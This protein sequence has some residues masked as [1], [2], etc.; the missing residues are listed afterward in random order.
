MARVRLADVAAQ[1]GVSAKTVSNVVHGTGM[2]SAPVRRRV[3]E[4]I[5]E[6]GYR[7]NLAARQLRN[8]TSGL[9]ALAIPDLREPYFAEFAS[10]FFAAAQRRSLTVLVSQTHGR[11]ENELQLY[12]GE[13]LPALEGLVMNPLALSAR[14]IADRRSSVPLVLF[15]EHGETLATERI[16]H[17]GVDNVRAAAAATRYLIDRGRRRIGVIG[18]QNTGST[19]TSRLRFE[20]YRRALDAAGLEFDPALV[21]AVADFNRAEGSAAVRR[22]IASGARFDALFCFNDSLAFGALYT[23]AIQDIAVPESVTVIGFDN[24]EE[25]RYSV[26]SFASISTDAGLTSEMILDIVT[27]DGAPG[28]RHRV[29]PFEVVERGIDA[30][31]APRD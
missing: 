1:V 19:A 20:G 27:G 25:G 3:L 10:G 13:G 14:D 29:V 2:V 24:I 8:G 22:L 26:P 15:G 6:L 7:P 16:P 28:D 11:R 4:V 18:V 12:E 17:V 23:L 5:D 31:A 9:V 21:G 30:P